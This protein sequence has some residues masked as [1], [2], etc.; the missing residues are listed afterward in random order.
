MTD[1]KDT[2]TLD[3]RL[4]MGRGVSKLKIKAMKRLMDEALLGK[5]SSIG[6][7]KEA[8]TTSDA[9]FNFAHVINLNFIPD[10]DAAPRNWTRI[11]GKRGA[12]DFNPVV[13]YSIAREWGDG[14]L[15][16]GDPAHVAPLVPEG[17]AYPTAYMKG[18]TSDSAR[19]RKRGFKTDFTF[20]AAINDPVGFINSLPDAMLEVA[21][22]TEEYEV[23][24]ALN[25]SLDGSNSF[26]AG[27]NPDGSSAPINSSLTRPALIQAMIQL[28]KRTWSGRAIPTNGKYILLVAPGQ[29]IY[30]DFILNNIRLS[31]IDEGSDLTLAVTGYNPLAQIEAVETEYFE[32]TKW[33]LVPEGGKIGRRP[34][35][36]HLFM[37]GRE[38]PELRVDNAQ[39]NYV[40]GGAV[41][42][43]EGSFDNDSTTF[44]IRSIG[45]AVAWTKP[46]FIWSSGKNV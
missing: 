9:I 45:D 46:A 27:T 31:T 7:L 5:H 39:G 17:T 40:G 28:G 18:E 35:L 6:T 24:K 16:D 36:E 3:G 19:L 1:Y 22:D 8:L 11:A 32:G 14:V 15:G 21:L 38:R 2:F 33:A 10:F 41:T 13:L 20:E 30:A 4:P 37:F 43:F 29:K 25:N 44:R 12:S 23:Y 26:V 42:P 34:V